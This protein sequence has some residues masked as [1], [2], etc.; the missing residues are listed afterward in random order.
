MQQIIMPICP[1]RANYLPL[2]GNDC[3][4]NYYFCFKKIKK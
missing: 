3:A 2:D 4:D 1:L